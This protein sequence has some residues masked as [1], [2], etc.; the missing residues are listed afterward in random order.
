MNWRRLF[1]PFFLAPLDRYLRDNWPVVWRTRVH[2][3]LFYTLIPLNILCYLLGRYQVTR[4]VDVP[5]FQGVALSLGLV[6]G[7]TGILLQFWRADQQRMPLLQRRGRNSWLSVGLYTAALLSV[8]VSFLVYFTPLLHQTAGLLPREEAERA[9]LLVQRW[10][11]CGRGC[12]CA[13]DIANRVS[14]E[15]LA[16]M[17]RLA[18]E[19]GYS[20]L[21]QQPC[22]WSDTNRVYLQVRDGYRSRTRR[23]QNQILS[24]DDAHDFVRGHGV[25]HS[26]FYRGFPLVALLLS[27]GGAWWLY[28][29]KPRDSLPQSGRRRWFNRRKIMDLWIIGRLDQFLLRHYPW[30]WNTQL[31]R[32][33][34]DVLFWGN[35]LLLAV[36][37]VLP[38]RLGFLME[39][40]ILPALILVVWWS[41]GFGYFFGLV[42]DRLQQ[43][44]IRKSP[45]RNLLLVLAYVVSFY[46]FFFN[47]GLYL[48]A[49]MGRLDG[50]LTDE[51]LLA[52]MRYRL[53][54]EALAFAIRDRTDFDESAQGPRSDLYSYGPNLYRYRTADNETGEDYMEDSYL[55][56]QTRRIYQVRQEAKRL[57]NGYKE[58]WLDSLGYTLLPFANQILD[59][60]SYLQTIPDISPGATDIQRRVDSLLQQVGK[61]QDVPESLV[62]SVVSVRRAPLEEE[63]LRLQAVLDGAAVAD[64]FGTVWLQWR[65]DV[66]EER[67]ARIREEV[68]QLHLNL[69]LYDSLI[70]TRLQSA[71]DS[72]SIR[73]TFQTRQMMNELMSARREMLIWRGF[74]NVP[75][76]I[77]LDSLLRYSPDFY[78]YLDAKRERERLRRVTFN[79]L[80]RESRLELLGDRQQYLRDS[81]Q[82]IEYRKWKIRYDLE[83]DRVGGLRGRISWLLGLESSSG[84][85]LNKA[86]YLFLDR[87]QGELTAGREAEEILWAAAAQVEEVAGLN[88]RAVSNPSL[89][90]YPVGISGDPCMELEEWE[91]MK[92]KP[93]Y[94]PEIY[95]EGYAETLQL[96]CRYRLQEKSRLMR[97][98]ERGVHTLFDIE[99][100]FT[101]LSK[102]A[103]AWFMILESKNYCF[104]QGLVYTYLWRLLPW[105]IL[106]FVLMYM[107]ILFSIPYFS[108]GPLLLTF[109]TTIAGGL[110]FS[111]VLDPF[112]LYGLM[113]VAGIGYAYFYP[114][115]VSLLDFLTLAWLLCTPFVALVLFPSTLLE[116]WLLQ[117]EMPDPETVSS[118]AG[119]GKWIPVYLLANALAVLVSARSFVRRGS[120][121]SGP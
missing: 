90:E 4:L 49:L 69:T 32:W 84:Y 65:A 1:I 112:L 22:T 33:L 67:A 108:A 11:Q 36:V 85:N 72:P 9:F 111:E 107:Y 39:D 114:R 68:E 60:D 31:H 86:L 64:T 100:E 103:P 120:E 61:L 71:V 93:W 55:Y 28:R 73:D 37:H 21:V 8:G 23:F 66:L 113:S 19:M 96:S 38:L 34:W 57:L 81:L 52:D 121:P 6:V 109:F 50:L 24:L 43:F 46:A 119:F 5:T 118:A 30:W 89:L 77:S 25:Y 117:L 3:I 97:L 75:V 76:G 91:E 40:L 82:R 7:L 59:A 2:L 13:E 54:D 12:D 110:L 63:L 16:F 83:V 48:H 70:T 78:S 53:D 62:D 27:L 14:E 41:A 18:S 17:Q 106:P 105:V 56:A 104:Q 15:D 94:R 98:V 74:R 51:Q 29:S 88:A 35:L 92:K 115:E 116:N 47:A 58:D 26:Y 42:H 10:D 95:D 20:S 80:D 102:L 44:T 79:S 101:Y 99:L 87:H 45:W